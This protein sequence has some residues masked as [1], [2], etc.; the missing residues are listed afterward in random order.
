M[1]IHDQ[2]KKRKCALFNCF[3][4]RWFF[5][6]HRFISIIYVFHSFF[7]FFVQQIM[8]TKK[9]IN[10][11]W[12]AKVII[13]EHNEIIYLHW[14]VIFNCSSTGHKESKSIKELFSIDL[15]CFD[16]FSKFDF[17]WL[18]RSIN[19]RMLF[20]GRV[21]GVGIGQGLARWVIVARGSGIYIEDD[22]SRDESFLWVTG[23]HLISVSTPHKAGS[24]GIGRL[25]TSEWNTLSSLVFLLLFLMLFK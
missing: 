23:T 17:L 16:W 8:G 13:I 9:A 22:S 12:Y 20:T 2:W 4:F 25:K 11:Q 14:R 10:I 21:R 6:F 5:N 15:Y 3:D 19:Q 1:K 18:R 7:Q 24:L